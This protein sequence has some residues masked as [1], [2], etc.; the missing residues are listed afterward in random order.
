[1]PNGNPDWHVKEL[2]KLEVFFSKISKFLEDFATSYNLMIDKYYHQ[3]KDWTFRFRH[4]EGGLG[5]ITVKKS[6]EEECVWIGASWSLDDYDKGTRSSKY[7]E[8]EK[9]SLE[10]KELKE[11]LTRI[12]RTILSW[13]KEDL[14]QSIA[15]PY[16]EQIETTREEFD[17][18][19]EKY[20]IPKL[21]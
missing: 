15:N 3:G 2:P 11:F 1:M 18:Q 17:H 6:N 5:G 8:M 7:T 19:Y 12:L 10:G 21:D 13:Q 16:R 4:P 14:G 9:C 20:P